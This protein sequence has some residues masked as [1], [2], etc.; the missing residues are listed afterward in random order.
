MTS[1]V[2]QVALNV[3]G[4]LTGFSQNLA[5]Q[6][7]AANVPSVTVPVR[8]ATRGALTTLRTFAA[9]GSKVVAG[10]GVVSAG[11]FAGMGAGIAGLGAAFV[12]LGVKI[13]AQNEEIKKTFGDLWSDIQKQAAELAKPFIGPL[14]QV[15][16]IIRETFKEIGPS[17]GRIFSTLAP[18]LVPL[19]SGVASMVKSL[20]PVFESLASAV[21]PM[22]VNLGTAF[23]NLGVQLGQ[24]LTPLINALSQ[25]GGD[26]FTTL[27]GGIGQLLVALGPL[28]A[29]MIQVGSVILGPLLGAISQIVG[30]LGQALIPVLHAVAPVFVQLVTTLA[31]LAS[32]LFAALSP[33]L[34]SLVPILSQLF[35]ILAPIISTLISSLA[36][37]IQALVPVL[38]LLVDAVGRILLAFTPILPVISQ[39]IVQLLNG[40]LPILQPIINAIVQLATQLL[41]AL[42]PVFQEIQP[43]LTQIVLAIASLLPAL[44]PLIPLIGELAMA[45]VPLLPPIVNLVA[46]LITFLVPILRVLIGVVVQVVSTLLK[47]LIPVIEFLVT[48]IS[49]VANGISWFIRNVLGPV[50]RWLYYNVVKPV[51][52]FIGTLIKTWWNVTVKPIFNLVKWVI[53]N[54][55]APAIRWLWSNIV[56]P[57]FTQIGNHVRWAWNTLIKPAFNA[58]RS[59][60]NNIIAPAVRWLWNTIIKPTFSK[61]GSHIKWVWENVIRRAFDAVKTAVGRVGT[62]FARG[63]SA[64]RT[65]WSKVADY[66]KKPINFVIGTVYN[67]GIIGLWNKVMGWLKLPGS[68]KLGTFPMLESG[69]ELSRVQPMKVNRPKAIVGEGNPRYPEYVIPT[70]PKYRGRASALWAAAGGDMQLLAKGGLIGDVWDKVKK[71]AS[72]VYDLGK[73][74]TEWVTNPKKVFDKLTSPILN[75]AKSLATSPWGKAAAAIPPKMLEQVWKSAKSLTDAFNAGFGGAG[76]ANAVVAAAKSQLGVPYSWGGGGPNGPSYGFAQGAGIR[77]FDCSSLMQYAY[78]KGAKHRL[79]RTTYTQVN[80]GR[81]VGSRSDLRPGDLVFPHL[82]HVMMVTTPGAKGGQGMIEAPRTGL[83]VRMTS[84]R[85]MAAGARRILANIPGAVRGAA[86]SPK[87][88]ARAQF[89]QFGWGAAQWPPLE[90]LWER[91]SNWRWN[92]RNPSSGAYGIPQALPASK[93]A[94]AGADWRTNPRTQIRWGLGYIKNRY[95]SPAAAWAHSQRVGWYDQGGFLPPGLS[96][97]YNGTG[98]PEP[99]LAPDQWEAIMRLSRSSIERDDTSRQRG[100]GPLIG[101]YVQQLPHGVSPEEMLHETQFTLRKAKMGGVY[102][103]AT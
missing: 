44:L 28:L 32:Q 59:V 25:V 39:L 4:D 43:A 5:A 33:I 74:A 75:Q 21:A 91:E 29:T 87:A 20:M 65:A 50:F 15:A 95:G 86:G 6:L 79:S 19:V 61:I 88:F 98:Q 8:V 99:V 73:E 100:G 2:G 7:R 93:M 81:P 3:I 56:K 11:V 24:F 14:K 9:Q 34:V 82:G 83:N 64:I 70:D 36:P 72:K 30:S 96:T 55:V 84:F 85:G 45:L 51:F 89:S 92:A 80:E 94:S 10:L 23:A 62:A 40:L 1:V 42:L 38:G 63:A 48:V 60:I 97:V 52:G 78:W 46:Q 101:T 17:L 90:R 12:G 47:L 68:L 57:V 77:G 35:S 31:P 22:L 58:I 69:G 67:K 49:A 76:D 54:V 37:V 66:A 13:A 103:G 102:A 27:L 53:S 41:G 18:T 16:G 71:G 26:L